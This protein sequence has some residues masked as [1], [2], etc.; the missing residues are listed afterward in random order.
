MTLDEAI[1]QASEWV[2]A[3]GPPD[4][5]AKQI[6]AALAEKGFVIV[7]KEPDGAQMMAG[8]DAYRAA[9]NGS[10]YGGL[11]ALVPAYRAMVALNQQ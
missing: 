1:L 3:V 4:W 2:N 11:A 5:R 6:V 9:A 10:H 8:D 7:P